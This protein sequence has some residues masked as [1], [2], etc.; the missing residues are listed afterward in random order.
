[1]D[2]VAEGHS[3]DTSNE[4]F[5]LDLDAALE[6]SK[7]SKDG[8]QLDILHPSIPEYED[9]YAPSDRREG[10]IKSPKSTLNYMTDRKVKSKE[11]TS[12]Q[13]AKSTDPTDW[14]ANALKSPEQR[15][16]ERMLLE[17]QKDFRDEIDFMDTSMV[18]E[19]SE[20][21]FKYMEELEV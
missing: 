3:G 6:D 7:L 8:M 15:E 12:S 2:D 20:E 14:L 16:A 13:N 4:T 1:M 21:I 9:E 10:T 5:E 19:Y 17:A 11:S 18:A